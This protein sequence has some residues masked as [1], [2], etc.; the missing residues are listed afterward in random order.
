MLSGVELEKMLRDSFC[1]LRV[2][3]CSGL[4]RCRHAYPIVESVRPILPSTR[5]THSLADDR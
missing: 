3:N 4:C 2:T 1:E 5:Q